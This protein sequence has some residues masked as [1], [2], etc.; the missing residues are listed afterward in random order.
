M[1][2]TRPRLCDRLLSGVEDDRK[3]YL[4]G[5]RQALV[6]VACVIRTGSVLAVDC[7]IRNV[8]VPVV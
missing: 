2:K 1:E 8:S 6:A 5:N 4:D 7:I 3:A